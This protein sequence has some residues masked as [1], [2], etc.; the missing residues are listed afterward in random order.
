MPSLF[1]KGIA[2]LSRHDLSGGEIKNVVLNAAR[3][4]VRRGPNSRVSPEDFAQAVRMEHAGKNK[5]GRGLVFSESVTKQ[6][7]PSD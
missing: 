2:A 6:L 5:Q 3:I 7:A 4:A 1:V